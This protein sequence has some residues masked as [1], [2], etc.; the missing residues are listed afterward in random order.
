[1]EEEQGDALKSKAVKGFL[2]GG[3]SNGLQQILGAVF[4]IFLARLL[5]PSDYGM[6]A[7]IT[8]FSV[9]ASAFQESGF[10]NGLTNKEKVT[11]QDYNAVFWCSIFL[12]SILYIILFISAPYIA[13][14]FKTPELKNLSRLAFLSFWFGS[15][16]I[17]HNAYL[18]RNLLVKSRAI[19]N[20]SA[21]VISNT[22]G[23]ILAYNGYA[24]WGLAL[25]TIAYTIITSCLYWCF[26]DF[27]PSFIINLHPIK[28]IF[29]FSSK[30]FISNTFIN[31]NNHVF[32]I[33]LGRFYNP[34]DVGYVAQASKWSLMG[35]SVLTNMVYSVTQPT[36]NQIR[37]DQNRQIRVFRKILSFTAFLAFPALFGLALVSK[38]FILITIGL[39]WLQSSNY[40][41][42]L[43]I[44]GAFLATSSVLSNFILSQGKSSVYMWSIIAFGICQTLALVLSRNYGIQTMLLSVCSL[45]ILWIFI[46]YTLVRKY[47]TYSFTSLIKDIFIYALLAA[48]SAIVSYY[49]LS[50]ISNLY[51][52]LILNITSTIIFYILLNRIFTPTI[53]LEL[54]AQ[55]GKMIKFKKHI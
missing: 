7:M 19:T 36:L 27:R 6:I 45:Q 49:C 18:F 13:L 3:F 16:G 21:L 40:L 54:T 32:T 25:Q 28:E 30:I 11:Q 43:C 55:I 24:Y 50:F 12:S 4:G 17:A 23:I 44:G 1:M 34:T 51:I 53:L 33:V 31:I 38:E 47:I 39:D 42:I 26:S 9:I 29:G 52:K 5:S 48:L 41:Q 35:Q 46:W 14:Y 8:I 10:V 22:I 2:V 15:F 37:D 20:V